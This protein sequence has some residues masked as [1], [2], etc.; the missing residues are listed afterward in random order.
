MLSFLSRTLLAFVLVCSVLGFTLAYTLEW[1]LELAVFAATLLTLLTAM[2]LERVMPYRLQWNENQGD[3]GTDLTSALV[4]V[5]LTDPLIKLLAPLVVVAAYARLNLPSEIVL[6][7]SLP[8]LV[9]VILVTLL[10]EL[11][12]YWSHR[13]HHSTRPLWQ[14]HAMHHSSQRLYTLNN[15][16]FHP[17]NYILNFC[18]GVLPAMLLGFPS[19]ALLAYLAISQPVLMLQ[20]ANLRLNSGLLNYVFS[21]NEVHRWHHSSQTTEANSN[22]GNAIVLWDQVFGTFHYAPDGRNEPEAIGLFSSSNHY[23]ANAGYFRQLCASFRPQCC[24]G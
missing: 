13:L 18:I 22:Y 20:H 11:G 4:L 6:V 24:T 1:N 15:L 12:R 5:G 7:G 19:D 16:R 8:F 23:P 10:I 17:L 21:T 9:Q 2:V 3:L 14:L